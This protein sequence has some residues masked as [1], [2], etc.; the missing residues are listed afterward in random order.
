MSAIFYCA[1]GV[2]AVAGIILTCFAG[3]DYFDDGL[4]LFSIGALFAIAGGVA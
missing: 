3:S 4:K 1:S 2:F